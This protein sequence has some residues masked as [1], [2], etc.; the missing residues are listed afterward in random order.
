MTWVCFRLFPPIRRY[1]RGKPESHYETIHGADIFKKIK[2]K[3]LLEKNK[4]PK[5]HQSD[6]TLLLK[7]EKRPFLSA[8][9][10]SEALLKCSFW[11]SRLLPRKP[12]EGPSA[13]LCVSASQH[14]PATLRPYLEIYTVQLSRVF[15]NL[16]LGWA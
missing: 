16:K 3:M 9:V 8:N 2:M 13:R 4:S 7:V 6:K 1:V 14:L 15:I 10:D 12:Q 11:L 5:Y